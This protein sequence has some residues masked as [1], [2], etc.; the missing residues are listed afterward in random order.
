MWSRRSGLRRAPKRGRV[1]SRAGR[2]PSAR[3]PL[4]RS[5]EWPV[6]CAFDAGGEGP[7]LIW[8]RRVVVRGKREW[9]GSVGR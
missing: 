1:A 6:Y 2:R 5:A 3:C 9:Y 8:G 4:A 7:A